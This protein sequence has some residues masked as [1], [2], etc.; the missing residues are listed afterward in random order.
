M[1]GVSIRL[2][3]SKGV[4][5]IPVYS[6]IRRDEYVCFVDGVSYRFQHLPFTLKEVKIYQK[7][8]PCADKALVLKHADKAAYVKDLRTLETLKNL[9][10]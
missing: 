4:D 5:P 10:G 6:D 9:H 7:P 2:D 8:Q 3:I 1:D